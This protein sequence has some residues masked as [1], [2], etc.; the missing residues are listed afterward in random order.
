MHRDSSE[1]ATTT[2]ASRNLQLRQDDRVEL[3]LQARTIERFEDKKTFCLRNFRR[4]T[5]TFNRV[6]FS[7][8]Y[9]L[10]IARTAVTLPE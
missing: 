6:L 8:N 9:Y 5:L 7:S 10:S 4:H 2:Q 1:A 3:R